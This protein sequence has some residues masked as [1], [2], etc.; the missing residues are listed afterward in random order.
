MP[1]LANDDHWGE[2]RLQWGRLLTR[3]V[4]FLLFLLAPALDIFRLDLTA[5]GFILF[6]QQLSLGLS[7]LPRDPL[8]LGWSILTHAILPVLGVI[9]V[10]VVIVWRFGRLY[11]GWFCPH[12]SVVEWIN[13]HM[14]R[15]RGQPTLWEPASASGGSWSWIAVVASSLIMAFVWSVSLL[16][17]LLPPEEIF[18]NLST[19]SPTPNQARFIGVGTLLLFIDFFLARHLFCRFGCAVGLF[20]SLIWMA[21][22]AA[23]TPFFSRER[24]G[25]CQG[26]PQSCDT[27][28]PMRLKPRR[29]KNAIATC[30]Q[31]GLC[32]QACQRERGHYPE[33]PPLQWRRGEPI[34]RQSGGYTTLPESIA[35]KHTIKRTPWKNISENSG[36]DSSPKPPP[37]AIQPPG[38]LWKRWPRP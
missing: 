32:L 12:F 17:Y 29:G 3:S 36:T 38:S 25:I 5:G 6:G 7:G 16:T 18:Y 8:A 9:G 19:F 4:F 2:D 20:Q 34:A 22:R 30:T 28:C 13:G 24:A 11:C 23:L 35:G 27:V 10:V 15:A 33:G 37:I 31:C 21:N 26:C 14:V 1:L